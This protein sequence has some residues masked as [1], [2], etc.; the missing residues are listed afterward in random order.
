MNIIA[1]QLTDRSIL[2]ILKRSNSYHYLETMTLNTEFV[3]LLRRQKVKEL[4]TYIQIDKY[5]SMLDNET[6]SQ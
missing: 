3:F 4:E 1:Y 6:E 5:I 2:L